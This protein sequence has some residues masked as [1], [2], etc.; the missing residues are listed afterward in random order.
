MYIAISFKVRKAGTIKRKDGLISNGLFK[1]AIHFN[2][3]WDCIW[4]LGLA[5]IS[6]NI[7]SLFIPLGLFLVFVFDY[8]PKSDDYLENNYVE[9]FR[10]YKQK[11][12]N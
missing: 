3:L 9:Q 12:K 8:I 4:V 6:C 10:V 11:T 7:F 1:Y 5:L 2:Y